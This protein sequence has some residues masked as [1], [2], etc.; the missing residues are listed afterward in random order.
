MRTCICI[1]SS[2]YLRTKPSKIDGNSEIEL[3]RSCITSMRPL[4]SATQPR[5]LPI[6]SLLASGAPRQHGSEMLQSCQH[7]QD[8]PSSFQRQELARRE[9]HSSH[10]QN[11]SC[12]LSVTRLRACPSIQNPLP[13][14]LYEHYMIPLRAVSTMAHGMSSQRADL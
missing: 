11:C 12:R 13:E 7:P 8:G 2:G 9:A 1:C 5:S 10:D 14:T 3:L 4:Q 6:A